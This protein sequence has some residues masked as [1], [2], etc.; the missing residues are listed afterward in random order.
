M[1]ND[2]VKQVPITGI[3]MFYWAEL[4]EDNP[5][6]GD[7]PGKTTYKASQFLPM[8]VSAALAANSQSSSYWASNM[9]G[10]TAAQLGDMS[11]QL[12]APQIPPDVLAAWYG[13][14]RKN[15]AL[16][17]SQIN[18]KDIA[19]GYRITFSDNHH[20]YVWVLK[21]KPGVADLAASTKNNSI[22][23]QDGTINCGI[24]MRLSDGKY[25]VALDDTDPDNE[26]TAEQIAA[27]FFTSPN[28]AIAD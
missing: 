19:I 22:S 3:D 28:W 7:T 13:W 6:Q 20:L 1:A 23:F 21:A 25:M 11:L 27:G 16:L 24:A 8:L 15:G 26:K 18:P 4:D 5:P 10:A 9:I 12:Q 2:S 14:E 17:G